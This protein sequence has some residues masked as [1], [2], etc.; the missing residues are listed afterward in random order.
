MN[1]ELNLLMDWIEVQCYYLIRFVY[2]EDKN[3]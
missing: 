2:K 1:L 3:V